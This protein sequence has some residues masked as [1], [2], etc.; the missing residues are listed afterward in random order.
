[1]RGPRGADQPHIRT[2]SP[3]TS[4]QAALGLAYSLFDRSSLTHA[5]IAELRIEAKILQAAMRIAADRT[6]RMNELVF[7][8][9]SRTEDLRPRIVAGAA[10]IATFAAIYRFDFGGAREYRTQR[11]RTTRG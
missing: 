6:D 10:G 7:E 1:M 3:A 9:L 5:A 4:A 11:P 2:A 8:C